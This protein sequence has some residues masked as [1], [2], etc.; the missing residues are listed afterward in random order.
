MIFNKPYIIAEIGVNYYDIAKKHNI[1]LIEAAKLMIKEAKLNGS[2]AIKFQTY[3][4]GKLA[5]KNSPAYWD[6][7]KEPTFNQYELFSNFSTDN[8][9]QTILHLNKIISLN[10]IPSHN[11]HNFPNLINL[12]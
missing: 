9:N 7:T 8:Q 10:F 1:S 3:K 6:T 2:D 5:S 12:I 4:A 11:I